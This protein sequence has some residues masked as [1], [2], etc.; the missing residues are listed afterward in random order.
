LAGKCTTREAVLESQGGASLL[1]RQLATRNRELTVEEAMAKAELCVLTRG[2]TMVHIIAGRA[3]EGWFVQVKAIGKSRHG[4]KAWRRVWY[5]GVAIRRLVW[6]GYTHGMRGEEG[7]SGRGVAH[8]SW[9]CRMARVG[10]DVRAWG[11]RVTTRPGKC[12]TI[13]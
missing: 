13:A 8:P 6:R 5:G 11:P 2:G 10:L 4:E 9:A 3:L 7:K 12:R 1:K